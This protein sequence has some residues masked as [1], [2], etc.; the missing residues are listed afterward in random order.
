LATLPFVGAFG[1]SQSL[2][3]PD[4]GLMQRHDCARVSG[5]MRADVT[6]AYYWL[7]QQFPESWPL[8]R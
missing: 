3:T 6:D 7:Q 5:P 2:A 4:R 8:Q 1:F